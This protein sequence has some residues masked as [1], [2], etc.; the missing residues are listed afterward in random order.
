MG[1]VAD[2]IARIGRADEKPEE[3]EETMQPP[4]E[5][6]PY[7]RTFTAP[8]RYKQLEQLETQLALWKIRKRV[9]VSMAEALRL[10]VDDFL[11]RIEEEEDE[12]IM[13]LYR[14]ETKE[15][16]EAETRKYGRSEG[17]ERYLKEQGLL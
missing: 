6:D 12:V 2:E 3:S 17:A 8:F 16:R 14:Q 9:K 11:D 13:D 10:A 4:E 7:W 15:A 5:E 1:E